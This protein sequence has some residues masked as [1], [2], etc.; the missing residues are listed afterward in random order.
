MDVD[1]EMDIAEDESLLTLWMK[2]NNAIVKRCKDLETSG[3]AHAVKEKTLECYLDFSHLLQKIQGLPS[4]THNLLP[5]ELTVVYN[6]VI[7]HINVTSGFLC[8]HQK[9]LINALNR[10]LVSR[11]QKEMRYTASMELWER[12]LNLD[13]SLQINSA[14]NRLAALQGALWLADNHLDNVLD[15]FYIVTQTPAPSGKKHS[16]LQLMKAW[17]VP[18]DDDEEE[19]VN[20]LQSAS[21]VRDILYTSAAFMQGLAAME[22]EDFTQAV[23]Y[24]QEAASSLCTSRVLAEIYTCLGCSF[25]RLAKPQTALQFWK[26]ALG[27]NFHCLAALYHTSQLYNDMGSMDSE[28]EALTL[29]YKAL[30]T[31]H[32]EPSSVKSMFLFRV[33]LILKA[34]V[35][36]CY[37]HAPTSWEVKYLLANHCLRNKSVELATEHYMD[38]MDALLNE[39]QPE[40]PYTSPAPLPRMPLIFLEAASALLERDEFQDAITVCEEILG[41][42][43]HITSGI[44]SIVEGETSHDM[45][46]STEQLNCV[47]WA[48]TAHF[49]QGEAQGK[50]GNCKESVAEYTR[51]LNVLMKIKF[52]E[53]D[54]GKAID[55]T[56]DRNVFTILKASAFLGRSQ[57]LLEIGD[58][59]SALIN[60]RFALQVIQ[61]FP[62]A[63]L[64]LIG[65]LWKLERKKEAGMEYRRYKSNKEFLPDQYEAM[66]RDLPLHLAIRIK[67]DSLL[68]KSLI[69]ELEEFL[70]KEEQTNIGGL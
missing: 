55:H 32:L 18:N 4:T 59:K 22:A 21:H 29:L 50:L 23:C 3:D 20:I 49:F 34:S 45:D 16:L 65:L 19:E 24:L 66:C 40:S 54:V 70:E 61:G 39:S 53:S 13:N 68:D 60:V 33:E 11:G 64:F 35:L 46:S 5:L 10:V 8:E 28:L 15:L 67:K 31:Y 12:V 42:L 47:L 26:Q 56:K 51:C 44:T 69:K 48:S 25:Y 58:S 17:K 1:C 2:E 37:I 30:E 36:S 57:Q 43:S 6:T 62:D 14:L 7:I 52:D 63:V 27:V 38:L 9:Q 41:K